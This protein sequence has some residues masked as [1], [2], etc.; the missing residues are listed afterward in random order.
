MDFYF[1]IS[2]FLCVSFMICNITNKN[3][4]FEIAKS[5]TLNLFLKSYFILLYV[6]TISNKYLFRLR[7]ITYLV[8]KAFVCVDVSRCRPTLN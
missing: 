8:K 4:H 5:Y 2:V 6:G 3:C 1:C 7:D